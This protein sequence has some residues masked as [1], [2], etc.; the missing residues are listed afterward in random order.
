M[1]KDVQNSNN[2]DKQ[3]LNQLV[4]ENV[5]V[6]TQNKIQKGQ[7]LLPFFFIYLNKKYEI[8]VTIRTIMTQIEK[9]VSNCFNLE[10]DCKKLGSIN[11][12]TPTRYT[13]GSI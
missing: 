2:V 13:I 3:M 5:I 4:N 8:V 7:F 6:P 1:Y 11:I 12:N 10:F 9:L